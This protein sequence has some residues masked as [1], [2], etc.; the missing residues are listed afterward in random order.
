[1][2]I[3]VLKSICLNFPATT[4]GIKWEE[5]LCFMVYEKI[6]CII[7]LDENNV[8]FKV[9]EEDFDQLTEREN[10]LQASHFAKRKWVKVMD[11]QALTNNEWQDFIKQSYQLVVQQLPK[12]IQKELG[13]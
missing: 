7:G 4:E 10:I 6:F 5:H 11:W 9:T 8:A 2:D 13:F 3:E 12:K 1:M